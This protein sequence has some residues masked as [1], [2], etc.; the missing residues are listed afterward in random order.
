M[1][2]S[3]YE[4]WLLSFDGAVKLSDRC[5]GDSR[6][7]IQQAQGLIRCLK[8]G[9]QLLLTEFVGLRKKFRSVKLGLVKREYNAATDYL[10]TKTLLAREPVS[11]DDPVE[12]AQLRQ[13]KKIPEKL[14]KPGASQLVSPEQNLDPKDSAEVDTVPKPVSISEA[15]APFTPKA[16]ICMVTRRQTWAQGVTIACEN[17]NE[18]DD[19]DVEDE[20]SRIPEQQTENYSPE[21]ATPVEHSTKRWR[22]ILAQQQVEPWTKKLRDLLKGDLE[23]LLSAEA[24]GVAKIAN[25]FV[26]DSRGALYYLS[27]LTLGRPRNAAENL[28]LVIL[29]GLR[30][31]LLHLCHGDF[32]GGHQGITRTF[33]R[34]RREFYWFVMHAD[35]GRFVKECVDCVTAKGAPP[36]PGPS[37]GNILATRPFGVVS[38]DFVSHLPKF[39]RG[40]V[41]LLL[42]QCVFSGFI[43][44]R[45]MSLTTAQDVAE[46]YMECVFQWFGASQM[47]RH[48]RDPRIMCEVFARFR[49]MLASRQ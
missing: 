38:M 49:E 17:V 48:D 21:A 7:A 23:E 5:V 40:N 2:E 42:F 27:R 43:M 11:I 6:I 35:V 33:K 19:R 16:W 24:E 12:L 37:T 4:G 3:D 32:Q 45:P 44:C 26:L 28:R 31:D 34:L 29:A 13:L 22:R 15:A 20:I 1:I 30:E 47:I 10:T 8:P 18:V 39:D 46:V 14:I 36:N 9:L 41:F 25:Q